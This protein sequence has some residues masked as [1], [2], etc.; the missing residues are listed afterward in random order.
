MGKKSPADNPCADLKCSSNIIPKP[1]ESKSHV[2]NID[3]GLERSEDILGLAV[4][5]FDLGTG[6]LCK[7][8]SEAVRKEASP[9]SVF[10]TFC[11]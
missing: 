3:W 4:S 5:T 8:A 10:Q 6:G 9:V 7:E 11:R 1:P 2:I